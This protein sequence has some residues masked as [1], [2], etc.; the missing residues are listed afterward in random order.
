MYHFVDYW[1]VT[2]CEIFHIGELSKHIH[3]I[4]GKMLQKNAVEHVWNEA[5]INAL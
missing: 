5:D 4:S 1:L 3:F 2:D